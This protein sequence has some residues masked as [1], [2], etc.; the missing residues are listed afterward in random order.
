MHLSVLLTTIFVLLPVLLL[1]GSSSPLAAYQMQ[2][3]VFVTI[4]PTRVNRQ[5][6]DDPRRLPTQRGAL[7]PLDSHGQGVLTADEDWGA[8]APCRSSLTVIAWRPQT[9]GTGPSKKHRH[10]SGVL[11][12]E[13]VSPPTSSALLRPTYRKG[14][15]SPNRP[16]DLN[17]PVF[18]RSRFPPVFNILMSIHDLLGRRSGGQ[19]R[20]ILPEFGGIRL[21]LAVERAYKKDWDNFISCP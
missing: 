16:L 13:L 21:T 6:G 17:S 7:T 12:E 9:T 4:P 20:T 19:D 3:N 1:F 14:G 15:R 5:I 10:S 11:G 18:V 8:G 2:K